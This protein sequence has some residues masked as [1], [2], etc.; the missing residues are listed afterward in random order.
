MKQ[1]FARKLILEHNLALMG[2]VG[3]KV[4]E[5][6]KGE[7]LDLLLC[8]NPEKKT[9]HLRCHPKWTSQFRIFLESL[10]KLSFTK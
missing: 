1:R 7:F 10:I 3:T 6:N 2:L 9:S 5:V 4:G 8:N